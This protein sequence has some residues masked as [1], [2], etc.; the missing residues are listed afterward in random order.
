MCPGKLLKILCSTTECV[1]FVC[2]KDVIL[3]NIMFFF[4]FFF[5]YTCW[6]SCVLFMQQLLCFAPFLS[7]LTE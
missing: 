6:K 5:F 4:L 2:F 1:C 3:K 7:Q